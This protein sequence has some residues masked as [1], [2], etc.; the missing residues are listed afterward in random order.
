MSFFFCFPLTKIDGLT[1]YTKNKSN[2]IFHAL[3]KNN[4]SFYESLQLWYTSQILWWNF[5]AAWNKESFNN[6]FQEKS[7]HCAALLFSPSKCLPFRILFFQ[8]Y[9]SIL[10]VFSLRLRYV[11]NYNCWMHRLYVWSSTAMCGRDIVLFAYDIF[12]SLFRHW[13]SQWNWC[14][15]PLQNVSISIKFAAGIVE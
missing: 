13:N 2:D 8:K 3:N 15:A 6:Y 14:L 10:I 12:P 9:S 11:F 7:F 1:T 5:G 4:L